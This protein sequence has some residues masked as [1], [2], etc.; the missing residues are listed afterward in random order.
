MLMTQSVFRVT[1]N[2]TLS[3]FS[4]G[5]RDSLSPD[6]ILEGVRAK[7]CSSSSSLPATTAD[8]DRISVVK[9][10]AGTFSFNGAT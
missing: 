10:W 3:L 5:R 1:S 7:D 8:V 4:G 6:V 9:G 2:S